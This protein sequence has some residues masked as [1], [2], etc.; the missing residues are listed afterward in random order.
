MS[1]P[2]NTLRP[3]QDLEN[4]KYKGDI[5]LQALQ[6]HILEKAEEYGV[7]LNIQLDEVKKSGLFN[8]ATV[9]CLEYHHPNHPT[10]YFRYVITSQKQ[11]LYTYLQFFYHGTSPNNGL[12]NKKN[13]GMKSGTVGGTISGMVRGAIAN[14]KSDQIREEDN[15]YDTMRDIIREIMLGE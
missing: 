1:I 4:I 5:S 11:G 12:I 8:K 3:C 2:E 14:S 6:N 9:P 13:S 15:W 10:D 7:P